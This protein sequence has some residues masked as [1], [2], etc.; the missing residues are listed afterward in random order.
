VVLNSGQRISADIVILGLGVRP[1][2][3]IAKDCGLQ[4]GSRGGIIVDEMLRTEDPHIWAVGDAIEVL[5][6]F[7]LLHDS[8]PCMC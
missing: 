3:A 6:L 7:L 5:L 8:I 4:L 2:T 1:D